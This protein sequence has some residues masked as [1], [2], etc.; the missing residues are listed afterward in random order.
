M[1]STLQ[2]PQRVNILNASMPSTLQC[3][4]RF[5]VKT[6][7]P[8][9]L[10]RHQHF[11]APNTSMPSTLQRPQC[12]NVLNASTSSTPQRPQR[13]NVPGVLDTS[14]F[15]RPQRLRIL[16]ALDAST[17]STLRQL[18]ALTSLKPQRPHSL[19]ISIASMR[20]RFNPSTRQRHQILN[21]LNVSTSTSSKLQC[22]NVSTPQH[23]NSVLS[24]IKAKWSTLFVVIHSSTCLLLS[25]AQSSMLHHGCCS[26][27]FGNTS[28]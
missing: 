16:N 12:L 25:G 27:N 19:D 9:S 23:F 26:V 15:Q 22:L 17:P 20:Q 3:P 8:P 7:T 2:C 13:F 6:S 10:Q 14:T 5:N 21:A 18:N 4:Q 11:N 28:R 1:P 24:T